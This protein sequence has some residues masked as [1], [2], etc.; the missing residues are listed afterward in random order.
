MAL[1]SVRAGRHGEQEQR[2]IDKGFVTIGWNEFSDP[3]SV[4]TREEL[5]ELYM[6]TY[7][8]AKK[9]TIANEVGQVWTFLRRI[10]VGDLVVLPSKLQS[11]IAIGTIA[12]AS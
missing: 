1:W 6:K 3:S 4:R 2:A 7:P 8:H 11:A 12:G 10:N 9:N 5:R